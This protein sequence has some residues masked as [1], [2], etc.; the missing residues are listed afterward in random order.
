MINKL[1]DYGANLNI[2]DS[3]GMTALHF[4]SMMGEADIVS[5]LLQ[6]GANANAKNFKHWSPLD[7]A[8]RNESVQVMLEK[9]GAERISCWVM[10]CKALVCCFCCKCFSDETI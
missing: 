2:T 5:L 6:R 1:I 3:K 7:M 8:S 9:H 4:M 10:F